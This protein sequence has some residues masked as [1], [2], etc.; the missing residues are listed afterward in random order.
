MFHWHFSFY[1]HLEIVDMSLKVKNSFHTSFIQTRDLS[2]VFATRFSKLKRK[3]EISWWRLWWP[4]FG[5]GTGASEREGHRR[6]ASLCFC[7][8][9]KFPLS[10]HFFVI[11]KAKIFWPLSL[12]FCSNMCSSWKGSEGIESTRKLWLVSTSEIKA[13]KEQFDHEVKIEMG[14]C[15]LLLNYISTQIVQESL[16]F[17]EKFT[18][19]SNRQCPNT[20]GTSPKA[21]MKGSFLIQQCKFG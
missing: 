18:P 6:L 12:L 16:F 7:I 15:K 10:F 4:S 14:V 11:V 9:K 2:K 3:I 19:F 1:Y 13:G 21:T 20:G 5:S 8:K 17:S